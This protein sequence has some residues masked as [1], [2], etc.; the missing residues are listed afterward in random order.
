MQ[1]WI[2]VVNAGLKS[3]TA[4][5]AR[6]HPLWVLISPSTIEQFKFSHRYKLTRDPLR[7]SENSLNLVWHAV[8][9]WVFR[10]F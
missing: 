8:L 10:H 2:F 4:F 7:V 3:G 9:Q 6:I 1:K 5:N